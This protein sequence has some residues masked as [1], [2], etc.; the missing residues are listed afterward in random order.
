MRPSA[1]AAGAGVRGRDPARCGGVG[2][3]GVAVSRVLRVSRPW[4]RAGR[5]RLYRQ[6]VSDHVPQPGQPLREAGGRDGRH[7]RDAGRDAGRAG[8]RERGVLRPA[9]PAQRAGPALRLTGG[10]RRLPGFTSRSN[11][12]RQ[13]IPEVAVRPGRAGRGRPE[14]GVSGNGVVVDVA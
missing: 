2:G 10:G 8:R 12:R 5:G 1:P 14:V 6:H 7:R 9:V 13:H 3:P 11:F 4:R